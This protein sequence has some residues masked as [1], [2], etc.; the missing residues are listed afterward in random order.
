M[1]RFLIL[2]KYDENLDAPPLAEW[3]PNDLDAHMEYLRA[4][5]QELI[6]NGELVEMQALTGPELAKVVQ[7][8]GQNAPVVTDGPFPE[9]KEL[10]AGYQ[11]VDVETEDRAVEIAA[12]VSA[13]P[14]PNGVPLGQPIEVRQVMFRIPGTDV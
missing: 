4:L 7:S 1:T 10:L 14:G 2:T 9:A 6:E 3:D 8:D 5:N 11:L 12:L 13:A